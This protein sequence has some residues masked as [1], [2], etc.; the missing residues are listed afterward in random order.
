MKKVAQLDLNNNVI[1]IYNSIKDAAKSIGCNQC[2]ISACITG[3]Q[4]M[5]HGYL[6]KE[7]K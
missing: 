1:A 2:G 5:S 6:W 7:A 3:R 4:K